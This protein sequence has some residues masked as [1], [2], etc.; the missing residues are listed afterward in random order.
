M[1]SVRRNFEKIRDIQVGD[2]LQGSNV[3][4]AIVDVQKALI[5]SFMRENADFVNVFFLFSYINT[6]DNYIYF[7]PIPYYANIYKFNL[8]DSVNNLILKN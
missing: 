8:Y 3:V 6:N 7:K 4:I 1:L 2:I 5:D